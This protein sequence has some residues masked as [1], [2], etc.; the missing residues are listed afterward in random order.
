[1]EALRPSL[2]Y[3]LTQP[4]CF[5]EFDCGTTAG[6]DDFSV[7]ELLNLQNGEFEDGS[8]EEGE[9]KDSLFV[10]DVYFTVS[11]GVYGAGDDSESHLTSELAVPVRNK[12]MG[13][14][15]YIYFSV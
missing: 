13:I 6:G 8:V 10:D 7:D 11:G 12:F 9:E 5:E 2:R 15:F 4:E 3:E 14:L 1:M